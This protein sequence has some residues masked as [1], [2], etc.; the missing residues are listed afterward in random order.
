MPYAVSCSSGT[1]ALH[2]GLLALGVGPGDEVIIPD[3]TFGASINAVIHSGATPVMVDI[4]TKSWNL[5]S[6]LV[7]KAITSRTKAIMTVHLYGLPCD[8]D[9]FREIAD[10]YKLSIIE[11]CAESLGAEFNGKK[12]RYFWRSQY[13]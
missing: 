4:D 1:T 5:D 11:D 8:M 13:F 7:E 2:L 10:K 9:C 3:L 6:R 12:N